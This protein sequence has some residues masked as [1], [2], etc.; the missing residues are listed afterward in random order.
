MLPNLEVKLEKLVLVFRNNV[1]KYS[2]VIKYTSIYE[3]VEKHRLIKTTI[4]PAVSFAAKQIMIKVIIVSM[5]QMCP[6]AVAGV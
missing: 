5:Y 6:G 3:I 2:P 1:G 4:V